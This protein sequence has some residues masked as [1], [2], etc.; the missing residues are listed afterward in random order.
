MDEEV[1]SQD[2]S[3]SASTAVPA[4]HAI[5][6]DPRAGADRCLRP[7]RVHLDFFDSAIPLPGATLECFTMR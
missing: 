3:I 1:I 4:M 2:G 5:G 6:A 7:V